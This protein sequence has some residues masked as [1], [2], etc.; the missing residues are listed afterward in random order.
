MQTQLDHDKYAA[1][2]N[3]HLL[4]SDAGMRAFEA[5][6]HSWADTPYASVFSGISD[7]LEVSRSQ[8]IALI[9]RLGYKVSRTRTV[10]SGAAEVAGRVNPLNPL[11]ST[12]SKGTQLELDSLV[13]AV[14]TQAMMW[15][16]LLALV[17]VDPRLDAAELSELVER[18]AS[19]RNRVREVSAKTAAARFTVAD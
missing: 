8:L 3:Q 6:A 17:D 16:T 18:C 5:A 10:L 1:Y 14:R 11:R 7:E 9:E 15:E 4:A 2:L 19:Q 12:D 13:G